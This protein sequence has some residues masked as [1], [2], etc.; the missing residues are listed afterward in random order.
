M[1]I[2]STWLKLEVISSLKFLINFTRIEPAPDRDAG[3]LMDEL[4]VRWDPEGRLT[5]ARWD[6]LS[7]RVKAWNG[8]G[9]K[10]HGPGVIPQ[11]V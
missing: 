7:H 11:K 4:V 1:V 3:S 6:R 5:Y 8:R 2:L 10:S 9:M